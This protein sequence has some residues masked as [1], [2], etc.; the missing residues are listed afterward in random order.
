MTR[1]ELEL[2]SKTAQSMVDKDP[3]H[4]LH[5]VYLMLAA[6]L[7]HEADKEQSTHFE[8]KDCTFGE[9]P[10][11]LDEALAKASKPPRT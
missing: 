1:F 6:L 11:T 8:L 9:D 2:A 7:K 10:I 5:A 4:E 3:A